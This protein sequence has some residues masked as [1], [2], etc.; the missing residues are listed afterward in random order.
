[1]AA[2]SYIGHQGSDRSTP[3]GRATRAGYTWVSIAE[4]VAAGQTTAEEVVNTWLASPGHCANLMNPRYSE[5]GIAYA[6]NSASE[7]GIYWAQVF[8]APE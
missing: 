6:V 8:A 1:M 2:R 5:M 4:N 7:K 3:A